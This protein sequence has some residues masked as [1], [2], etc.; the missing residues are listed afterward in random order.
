MTYATRAG[1]PNPAA[2]LGAL[3]VPA[4]FGAILV[5]GL[6]V[7][8]VI[9]NAPPNP[10]GETIEEVELTP[11]PPEKK[12]EPAET[13][14][15]NPTETPVTTPVSR[16]DD[17]PFEL[18]SS[19]PIGSLPGLGNETIGPVDFG[20]PNLD[21]ISPPGGLFDPVAA[22]PR[23]NPGLWVTDKDYKSRWVRE[24]LSGVTGFALTIDVTGKVSAC[25]VTRSSGHAR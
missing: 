17:I 6:A 7:N 10:I 24:G 19:D 2:I 4:A 21:P 13:T 23:N 12:P 11:L 20:R 15:S 22:A 3:G 25:S 16:P 8:V 9:Q 18:G 5:T 1:R 14:V